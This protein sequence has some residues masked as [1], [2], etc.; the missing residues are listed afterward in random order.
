MNSNTA[1]LSIIMFD[2]TKR[3]PNHLSYMQKRPTD[4]ENTS[5]T[6]V[7]EYLDTPYLSY[8]PQNSMFHLRKIT[9]R[10]M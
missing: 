2:L 7:L 5:F 1:V 6:H 8:W 4:D 3:R 9:V 10:L